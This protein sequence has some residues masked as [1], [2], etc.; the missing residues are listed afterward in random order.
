MVVSK[1]FNNDKSTRD[2]EG[3]ILGTHGNKGLVRVKFER[4]MPPKSV[5]NIVEVRLVKKEIK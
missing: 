4:N 5:T 1:R 3:V 2:V